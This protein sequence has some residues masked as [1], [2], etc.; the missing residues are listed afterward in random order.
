MLLYDHYERPLLKLE[1]NVSFLFAYATFPMREKVNENSES[2]F[3][4]VSDRDE[5]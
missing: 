2:R 3:Y 1:R 4:K 5:L